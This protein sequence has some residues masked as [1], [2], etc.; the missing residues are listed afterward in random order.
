MPTAT[1]TNEPVGRKSR[2]AHVP[3]LLSTLGVVVALGVG[4]VIYLRAHWPFAQ[5]RLIDALQESSVRTV[6]IERFRQTYF[7]PGCVAEGVH[8]LHRE[9][10]SKPP[11]ITIEK[12]VVKGSYP[13]LLVSP[14]RLT[15]VFVLGMHVTV[16]PTKPG[17][18]NP[19]MPLTNV[20]SARPIVIGTVVAD[21][22][23]LEFISSHPGIAPIR[24]VLDKLALDGVG[25]NRPISYRATIEN[26][27]PPGRIQSSGRFGP[28]ISDDPGRT[29]VTGK[30]TFEHADLGA[31]RDMS[32]ILSSEG[33]FSGTLAQIEVSGRCDVPTLRVAQSAH[34]ER[35]TSE[36]QASVNATD[37]DTVLEQVQSHFNRTTLVSKGTVS[38]ADGEKGKVV[39]LDVS[40]TNGRIEDFLDMILSPS[41][42]AITGSINIRARVMVPPEQ[43][44]FLRKLNVEGD[45]G[46]DA[47]QFTAHDTQKTLNKLSDSAE[48]QDSSATA[49]SDVK[50]HLS[51]K[52]G[53]AT[54]TNVSFGMPGVDARLHG[55]Y[56]LLTDE[57]DLHGVLQ[58][59]G[60]VSV[61]TQ[62]FKSMLLDVIT[63]FLKHKAHTTL[64]P[65]KI[66]GRY[67]NP[68]IALDLFD[69]ATPR[70][71]PRSGTPL[72]AK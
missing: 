46:L 30:F 36:F 23:V 5:Q 3:I 39:T 2:F 16:P 24:L 9:D 43:V 66:T 48:A 41:R 44:E 68:A 7:P 29:A 69:S 35:L 47:A 40:S 15:K 28:W 38:G 71:K 26:P 25:N 22:T 59:H 42:P 61:A 65:F 57:V 31:F 10:K 54:L 33:Q 37:G 4:G 72:P 56:N 34:T 19:V 45:F 67:P 53:I 13:G 64:V 1:L 8:F 63:P 27:A 6:T 58:T 17:E 52:N 49:L 55:T 18:T 21:G 32:G 11:L 20:A 50:G 14:T 62:G 60:K 70:A 51:A 12:I